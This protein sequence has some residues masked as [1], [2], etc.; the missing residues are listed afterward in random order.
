M[1]VKVQKRASVIFKFVCID[2]QLV[3]SFEF[4]KRIEW[5][6]KPF[7][8]SLDWCLQHCW[9]LSPCRSIGLENRFKKQ[10]R[11]LKK[12]YLKYWM[13]FYSVFSRDCWTLADEISIN[14]FIMQ[15]SWPL[16]LECFLFSCSPLINTKLK[17][18]TTYVTQHEDI[19]LKFDTH[20]YSML[21]F[22]SWPSSVSRLTL[23][24]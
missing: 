13:N 19:H 14:D 17:W 23:A 4:F 7:G 8:W 12:M 20:E 1:S 24:D 22:W 3:F 21:A 2:R 16:V 15:W 9:A 11:R 10:K 18:V 6:I 5:I